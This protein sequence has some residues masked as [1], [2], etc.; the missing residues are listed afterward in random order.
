MGAIAHTGRFIRRVS[1]DGLGPWR[2]TARP[3]YYEGQDLR[4]GTAKGHW[5]F[6]P[7]T[8]TPEDRDLLTAFQNWFN[9]PR[10]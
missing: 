2:Y 5:E 1:N 4:N 6:H 8:L 3:E 9:L 10:N 7:A